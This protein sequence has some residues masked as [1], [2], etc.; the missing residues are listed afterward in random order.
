MN[1]SVNGSFWDYRYD[2]LDRLVNASEKGGLFQNYSYNSIGNILQVFDGLNY[3]NYTYGTGAGPHAVSSTYSFNLTYYYDPYNVTSTCSGVS[4]AAG[5]NWSISSNTSCSGGR[6]RLDSNASVI[7][8]A[9]K[10]LS[11]DNLVLEANQQPNTFLT[12]EAGSILDLNGS[13]V[14]LDDSPLNTAHIN[15]TTTYLY[16]QNG[17]MVNDSRYVY[18]YNDDSRLVRVKDQIGGLKEEYTYDSG[19]SRKVKLTVLSG[20]LNKTTLYFGQDWLREEYT[21]GTTQDTLYVYA[22][23]EMLARKDAAGNKFYYHPD[24]LGSTV[25]VTKQDGSLEERIQYEP[26]G[27]P[28]Q[29]SDELYQF[30]NQE[31]SG[32]LGIYDY[33]ARQYNPVLKRF[34]QAD[35]ILQNPY[36]PQTLNRY[37]YV[38]NN[39]QRY[40]DPTGHAIIAQ[41]DTESGKWLALEWNE[42]TQDSNLGIIEKEVV[43]YNDN[44]ELQGYD[45]LVRKG[46]T[47]IALSELIREDEQKWLRRENTA[48]PNILINAAPGLNKIKK[49]NEINKLRKA[50]EGLEVVDF[51]KE[52]FSLGGDTAKKDYIHAFIEG[53]DIADPTGAVGTSNAIYEYGYTKKYALKVGQQIEGYNGPSTNIIFDFS[54]VEQHDNGN[55]FSQ[56]FPW[57]AKKPD[58]KITKDKK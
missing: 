29:P 30:T 50:L 13:T 56:K 39:P 38:L 27:L 11:L 34:L 32:E 18:E 51:C 37:S 20:S 31:W 57:L 58:V 42:F 15:T 3:V 16:D 10:S 33:G 35:T 14:W 28:R 17:N 53:V 45:Y 44:G 12:L 46:D 40:T 22:N 43:M 41:Y 48:L 36:S 19:G 55:F 7:V 1:D 2:P 23:N 24:H 47:V 25:V 26:Y 4:P 52:V 9:N 5:S 8:S 54:H 6:V 21:N 49:L